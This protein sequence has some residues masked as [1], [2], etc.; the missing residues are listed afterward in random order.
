MHG[1]CALASSSCFGGCSVIC[2]CSWDDCDC[3]LQVQYEMS[4]IQVQSVCYPCAPQAVQIN[5][6]AW[7][8]ITYW[9]Q[10]TKT[11]TKRLMAQNISIQPFYQMTEI[12]SLNQC[13]GHFY[14]LAVVISAA[15]R[16]LT[17]GNEDVQLNGGQ[18]PEDTSAPADTKL[19][20][21]AF[22]CWEST[23]LSCCQEGWLHAKTTE[24]SPLMMMMR[25]TL[26]LI[27]HIVIHLTNI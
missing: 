20:I 24:H 7:W 17:S 26:V 1:H 25:M 2:Q 16:P 8:L 22:I 9:V 6:W 5:C 4:L 19:F 13:D 27:P 15:S 21:S 3:P 11:D 23:A 18:Q 12:L 10:V 14:S